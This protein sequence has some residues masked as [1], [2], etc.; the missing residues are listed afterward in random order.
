MQSGEF[1]YVSNIFYFFLVLYYDIW[2][3][4]QNSWYFLYV[5]VPPQD[6]YEIHTDWQ[7]CFS[8]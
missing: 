7:I 5:F 2:V 6:P 4:L 3:V 8:Q 1:L